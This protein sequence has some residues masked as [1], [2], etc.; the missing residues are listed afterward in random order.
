[1]VALSD[2]EE[3]SVE[4]LRAQLAAG[5]ELSEPDLEERLPSGRAK[6]FNNR[7]GWATTYLYCCRLVERPRRSVYVF[8]ARGWDVLEDNP[9]RIDLGVLSQFEEF[10]EF[11][12]AHSDPGTAPSTPDANGLQAEDATPEERIAAAYGELRGAL[13]EELRDRMLDQPPEFLEQLVLGALRA[14]G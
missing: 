13:A 8:T 1:M 9:Q 5:F 11:R 2:D 6:T 12:R 7:V 4:V 14:M 10:H 3:H